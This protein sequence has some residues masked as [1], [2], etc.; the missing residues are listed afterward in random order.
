MPERY[1]QIPEGKT[2]KLIQ[3]TQEDIDAQYISWLNDGEVTRHLSAGLVDNTYE[4]LLKSYLRKQGDD[5]YHYFVVF[6]KTTNKKI[7][8]CTLHEDSI[9]QVASYGYLIGEKDFWGGNS[10][11]ECQVV[12]L[13]YGFSILG[14]RKI[15]AG[16]NAS[17]L[18]SMIN[19]N[20]IGLK[21]EGIKRKQ[22]LDSQ[23]CAVDI[24]EFGILRDEWTINSE[25]Y[26]PYLDNLNSR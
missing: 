18:P 20:R 1:I 4:N 21:R 12:L 11:L 23:G 3:F 22:L 17:N 10:A 26:N 6:H 9:N 14:L 2:I 5:S 25:R 24:H 15:C 19:C 8:T 16:V 7:G 13:N